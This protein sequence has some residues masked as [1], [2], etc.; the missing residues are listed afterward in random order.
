MHPR[1]SLP[2]GRHGEDAGTLATSRKEKTKTMK[3]IIG[4]IL[5]ILGIGIFCV[6]DIQDRY[7]TNLPKYFSKEEERFFMYHKTVEE[8]Q[9]V[10]KGNWN[11]REYQFPREEIK[12]IKYYNNVPLISRLTSK[13]LTKEQ[14]KNL[15]GIINNPNNFEWSET[16]WGIKESNYFFRFFNKA[17]KEIGKFWVC[18]DECGMTEISPWIPTSKYGGLSKNGKSEIAKLVSEI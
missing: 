7:E 13:E 12:T 10:I 17:D 5:T 11:K 16:T 18:F 6:I 9:E 1:P 4:V 3:K 14:S 2:F 15:I 8:S